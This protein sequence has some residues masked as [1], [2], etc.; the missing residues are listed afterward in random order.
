LLMASSGQND[1]L[2]LQVADLPLDSTDN[3]LDHFE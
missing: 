3:Q 1:R 2:E